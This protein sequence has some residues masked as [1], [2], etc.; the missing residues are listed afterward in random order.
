LSFLQDVI[1]FLINYFLS[2]PEHIKR[3]FHCLLYSNEDHKYTLEYP[4][5]KTVYPSSYIDEHDQEISFE[6]YDD[7]DQSCE[8]QET[9]NDI[10]PPV[11]NIIPSK[12]QDRYRPLIFPNTLHNLLQSITNTFP[13]LMEN[14]TTL[15]PKNNFKLLRISLKFLK[16]S[17][18]MF[19]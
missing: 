13:Y 12:I 19:V 9:K 4:S 5:L 18:M 16:L 6:L 10:I 8:P 2:F 3:I 14:L 15:Q 1:L 17:M 11:H 7:H